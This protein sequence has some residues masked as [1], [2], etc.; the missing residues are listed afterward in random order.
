VDPLPVVHVV[1]EPT[2]LAER[3]ANAG[4]RKRRR[5]R[6]DARKIMVRTSVRW[7]SGTSPPP[8][9]EVVPIASLRDLAGPA[10]PWRLPGPG[11][12]SGRI[13]NVEYYHLDDCYT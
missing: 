1:L 13:Q 6:T 7:G 2:E 12:R 8:R 11:G 3:M 4:R 10:L 9:K 5:R